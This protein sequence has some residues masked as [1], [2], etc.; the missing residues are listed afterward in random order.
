MKTRYLMTCLLMALALSTSAQRRKAAVPVLTPE[1]IEHQEKIERMTA[2]TAKI[3]FF[4]SIVVDKD[5]FLQYYNLNPAAGRIETFGQ[6]FNVKRQPNGFVY[7]P[8]IGKRRYLSQ[9]NNE[10][11]INLYYTDNIG[12]KLSRPTKVRGINDNKLFS[13]VNYPFMMGDGQTLYFAAD[14]PEGLGGYD[15]YITRYD[16]EKGRFLQPENIGMPFNSEANDYMFVI[17]EYDSLGWFVTDRNQPEG[18]V[19]I[20]NFIPQVIRLAYDSSEHTPEEIAGFARIESIASTWDDKTALEAALARKRMAALRKR[21]RVTGRDFTFVINDDVTYTRYAD[22]R[23]A[24]NKSRMRQLGKLNTSYHAL[25]TTL[26]KVRDYYPSTRG[27][28][29]LELKEEIIASEHKQREL[30]QQIH[31]LEKEI[32]NSENT[33]LNRK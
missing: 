14:G 25:T 15:I 9:E 31:H 2:A 30:R 12:N 3:L 8:E 32:R 18:K 27:E 10:G 7:T 33:Y 23:V 29:R 4:D 1:E 21:Q 11:I 5:R 24:A 6:A 28:E 19:C 16:A 22:F 20:Y 17:D 26:N 13:R